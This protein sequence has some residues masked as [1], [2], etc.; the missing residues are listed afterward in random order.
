MQKQLGFTT[1]GTHVPYRTTQRYLPP[2][3]ADIPAVAPDEAGTR[4]RVPE[5][6]KAEMT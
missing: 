5:G 1:V 4:L 3:R 2:G 6:C